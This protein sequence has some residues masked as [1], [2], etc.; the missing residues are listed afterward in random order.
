MYK[1]Q[2]FNSGYRAPNIDDMGTLGIVDFRYELPAFNLKPEQSQTFELGYK[3][4]KLK[5]QIT[6]AIYSTSVSNLIVRSKVPDQI[7]SGYPVYILSL[8]HI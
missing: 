2:A 5:Y 3:I 1:R 4:A 6:G 7:I 8:I